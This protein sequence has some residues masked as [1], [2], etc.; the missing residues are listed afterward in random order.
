MPSSGLL[1]TTILWTLNPRLQ[2][3]TLQ[4][5]SVSSTPTRHAVSGVSMS[6]SNSKLKTYEKDNIT[7][8]C[9]GS[10]CSDFLLQFSGY[11]QGPEF[12]FHGEYDRG[13]NV[14]GCGD[15]PCHKLRRLSAHSRRILLTALISQPPLSGP[16]HSR[17]SW[18]ATVRLHIQRL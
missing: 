4:A 6:T 3:L 11:Q 15:E 8:I 18:T 5:P 14:P 10:P 13:Y 16:S 7:D 9:C 12:S 1:P 17:S 2:V